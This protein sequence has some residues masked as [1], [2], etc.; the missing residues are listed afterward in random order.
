MRFKEI[1]NLI[2][3]LGETHAE[4]RRECLQ[5]LASNPIDG[6]TT[7]K[8]LRERFESREKLKYL[9]YLDLAYGGDDILYKTGIKQLVD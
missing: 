7:M 8:E 9:N 3:P 6:N 4:K 1:D 2:Y 5:R